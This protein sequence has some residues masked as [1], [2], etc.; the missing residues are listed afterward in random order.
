[1][2]RAVLRYLG[3]H[4]LALV[5]LFL[6][7]GGTSY[8]VTDGFSAASN[9]SLHACVKKH[10]GAMRLI[11]KGHCRRTERSVVWNKTG[12]A[13]APGVNGLAGGSGPTGS[14][15]PMPNGF[16][17][18]PLTKQTATEATNVATARPLAPEVPLAS[19][20]DLS[21]YGKC[22]Y[23]G[24]TDSTQVDIYPRTSQNGAQWQTNSSN[25]NLDSST[26]ELNKLVSSRIA[27][28]TSNFGLTSTPETI[29]V[30]GPDGTVLTASFVI[31][32]TATGNP[33]GLFKSQ[34]SCFFQ[35][36]VI[37]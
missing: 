8:A 3:T 12:L 30:V 33:S 10:G 37:G 20:G 6:A 28:G 1:M 27:S 16:T 14:V 23:G 26:P 9:G 11:S 5:A 7:L 19:K 18:I 22:M 35:G 2:V 24:N 29:H 15:G 36:Y 4:H 17:L 25:S 34:R 13:G 21:L 31:G 32:A